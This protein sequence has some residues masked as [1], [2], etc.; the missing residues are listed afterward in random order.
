MFR[1]GLPVRMCRAPRRPC[2]RGFFAEPVSDR[3]GHIGLHEPFAGSRRVNRQNTCR[4]REKKENQD[5]RLNSKPG[6]FHFLLIHRRPSSTKKDLSAPCGIRVTL[7]EATHNGVN[8]YVRVLCAPLLAERE[9]SS[10]RCYSSNLMLSGNPRNVNEKG[11]G[12]QRPNRRNPCMPEPHD[13]LSFWPTPASLAHLT[14]SETAQKSHFRG[15][16]WIQAI[17]NVRLT[18]G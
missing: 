6:S 2:I 5:C 1:V 8:R 11:S 15:T 18:E 17:E 14:V 4:S 3:P 16:V 7:A 12:K 10:S 13:G 9:P